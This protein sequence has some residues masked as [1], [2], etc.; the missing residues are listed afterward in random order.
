MNGL[1]NKIEISN[2]SFGKLDKFKA[3]DIVTW[4]EINTNRSGVVSE[5]FHSVQGG[6][7][8]SCAKIFCFENEQNYEV[9]CLN[10]KILSKSDITEQEN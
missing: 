1:K 8:I 9:L 3:G 5:L 4:S 2:K 10:L 7:H 6:R